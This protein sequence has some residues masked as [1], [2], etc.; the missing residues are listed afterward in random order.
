MERIDGNTD[1]NFGL[2]KYDEGPTTPELIVSIS[3]DFKRLG[4]QIEMLSDRLI[5][6]YKCAML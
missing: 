4:S 2:G 3:P 6:D 5:I 1:L